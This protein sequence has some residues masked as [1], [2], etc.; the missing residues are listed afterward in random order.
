M[1]EAINIAIIFCNN[2]YEN[3]H[4]AKILCTKNMKMSF[5]G[6]VLVANFGNFFFNF[7]FEVN[8]GHHELS[9]TYSYIIMPRNI[10]IPPFGKLWP[11]MNTVVFEVNYQL[12][13]F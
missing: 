12:P 10:E 8:C 7:G 13:Q 5:F 3:F 6:V 11:R 1:I 2:T 4:V 9:H